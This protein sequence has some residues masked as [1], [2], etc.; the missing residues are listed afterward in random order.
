M[1]S[2]KYSKNKKVFDVQLLVLRCG[3]FVRMKKSALLLVVLVFFFF[4]LIVIGIGFYQM[5][6]LQLLKL[7]GFSS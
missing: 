3:L 5:F 1:V 2:Q 6:V 4:F 7:C